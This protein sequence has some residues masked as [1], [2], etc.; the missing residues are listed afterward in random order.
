MTTNIEYTNTNTDSANK[1][2]LSFRTK[3][4]RKFISQKNSGSKNICSDV[5]DSYKLGHWRM[6]KRLRINRIFSYLEAR[7]GALFDSTTFFGLQPILMQLERI[8]GYLFSPRLLRKDLKMEAGTLYEVSFE[9]VAIII[10][11]PIKIFQI[12]FEC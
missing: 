1:E 5:T 8:F 12:C 11:I 4:G 7:V 9:L 10:C 2:V 3:V 6:Y